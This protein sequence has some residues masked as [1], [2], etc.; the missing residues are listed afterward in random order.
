VTQSHTFLNLD[1]QKPLDTVTY[2]VTG[3]GNLQQLDL[4]FTGSGGLKVFAP[5]VKLDTHWD[6]ARL[7][8]TKTFKFMVKGLRAGS[9]ELPAATVDTYDRQKG[10]S[11]LAT[12]P[13]AVT[14]GELAADPAAVEDTG[15]RTVSYELLRELPVGMAVY[16]LTPLT[17]RPLFRAA[18]A[19]PL[20]LLALRALLFFARGVLRYRREKETFL[21]REWERRIEAAADP[22]ALLN[23]Y[24]EALKAVSGIA[25]K[26]ERTRE[27]EKRFAGRTAPFIEL[28]RDLQNSV[29]SGGAGSD[30]TTLKQRAVELLR[31]ARR[32][33]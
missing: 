25:L 18:L 32:L 3:C 16:D 1:K 13:V 20:L 14:V 17:E 7:C 12:R 26:G 23:T 9:Y 22:S 15:K 31:G 11:T 4:S 5:D 10:W 33:A 27:M 21:L 28:A 2:T 8:G 29:Y 6:G 24:Y 30:L 19:L